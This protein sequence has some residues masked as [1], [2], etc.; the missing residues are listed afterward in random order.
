MKKYRLAILIYIVCTSFYASAQS[1]FDINNLFYCAENQN[2]LKLTML[3]DS[4]AL[5]VVNNSNSQYNAP[6]VSV[7]SDSEQSKLWVKKMMDGYSL[8]LLKRGIVVSH[9]DGV[10]KVISINVTGGSNIHITSIGVSYLFSVVDSK[11]LLEDLF[12]VITPQDQQKH[13]SSYFSGDNY[14]DRFHN[15][16]I[17]YRRYSKKRKD[18]VKN[19][20]RFFLYDTQE[21]KEIEI[22]QET[23]KVTNDWF[24]KKNSL[25]F[26]NANH[27]YQNGRITFS[28]P[29]INSVYTFDTL[30]KKISKFDFPPLDEARSHFLY[31]DHV[32]NYQYV[33]RK[34]S[35]QHYE[36]FQKIGERLKRLKEIDF[37][38]HGIYAGKAHKVKETKERDKSF[39]CHYLI[40]LFEGGD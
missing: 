26:F 21:E 27:A 25:F 15:Y 24:T 3:T 17:G 38:P 5:A 33:V 34:Y 16:V 13:A 7:T 37:Y 20:P 28:I 29:T 32:F 22:N 30:S 12:L 4:T 6:S 40:P 36:V 10:G 19:T 9:Y 1:E 18:H 39:N 35:E 23:D 11:L 31:Y 14:I 8:L 2:I